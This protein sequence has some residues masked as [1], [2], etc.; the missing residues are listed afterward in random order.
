MIRNKAALISSIVILGLCTYLFFPFPNNEMLNARSTFMS[1][2]IRNQDGYVLF[3]IIGSI[4]FIIAIILV[5]YGMKK[6]HFRTVVI[7]LILYSILPNV[8]ITMYQET[9]ANGIKAISYDGN[10]NCNFENVSKDQLNGE[11]NLILQNHSNKTVTFELEFIDS[12]FMED[13]VRMESLM[14]TAGPY[15]ITIGANQKKSIHLKELLDLS[16]VPNHIHSGESSN[17]HFKIMDGETART[18]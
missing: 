12:G 4:L 3:G 5:I 1:F 18:L 10:G 14:N 7:V 9:V 13:D 6:Y 16:N 11:C 15:M 2:P 17:V 8:L